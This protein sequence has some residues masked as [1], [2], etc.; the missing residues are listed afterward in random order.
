MKFAKHKDL[1]TLI[2]LLVVIAIIAILAAM[3]LP[4]LTQA[5]DKSKT[6]TCLNNFGSIGKAV[7]MYASDNKGG[8][9]SYWNRRE[10]YLA[11]APNMRSWYASDPNNGMLSPYLGGLKFK[12]SNLPIGGYLLN[13]DGTYETSSFACPATTLEMVKSNREGTD[14]KLFTMARN[15]YVGDQHKIM[16]I[17]SYPRPSRTAFFG[18]SAGN[19][20]FQY[21]FARPKGD[22]KYTYQL[23]LNHGNKCNITFLDSHVATMSYGQ[24]PFETLRD[25]A[26]V[27]SFWQPLFGAATNDKW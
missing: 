9:P 13:A 5:R 24:I 1:F 16:P 18:D 25:R 26:W 22:N 15:Y 8:P 20:Q 17:S 11:T 14:G 27:L 2:E 6:I 19:A 12:S 21:C 4:A 3:L 23:S 10:G 7:Q